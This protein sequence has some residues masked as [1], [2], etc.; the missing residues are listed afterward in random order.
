MS[1]FTKSE[2][3]KTVTDSVTGLVWSQNTVASDV[4][5]EDAVKAVEALGEGWRLPTV[6]ELQTIVDRTKYDPAIDTDA[7]PDTESDWYWTSTPC[8]WRP[9]SARWVVSF[10]I[11][12]V[13]SDDFSD[14]ACVRAVRGGQ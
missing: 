11:G 13:N 2:D 14:D 7:F 8:A 9:E 3:G 10:V 12:G 1:R 4:T 5:F 6:D